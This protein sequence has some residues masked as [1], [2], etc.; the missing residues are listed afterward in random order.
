M[1]FNRPVITHVS[2]LEEF[3]SWRDY[4]RGLRE[5]VLLEA[6]RSVVAE[7]K[8]QAARECFLAFCDIMKAGD[9]KVAEFHEIIGSGFE[10]LANRRYKRL[11]VSCPPRSGK[12]MLATMFLAWL[13]GRDQ[14]TQHVIASYGAS[15]SFKFHRETVQ[16]L[17]SKEFKR[18]FPEWQGFSPDSK[19]DM[20]GGGYILATSIGGVLTGFT[21]GTTDMDSPGVGAMII[22]DPL[23]SSDSKQALD[24]L[25]S[26]WQE[27]ASTRRT[28]HFCQMVIATRFHEKDLHGV[29]MDGD[30][31]LDFEGNGPEWIADGKDFGWRW[32]N[33]SGL[34]EDPENDP[35][36]RQLGESHWPENS[37]FSVPMLESQKKIMGSFKF[38]ALYQGVPVASEGQ[39]VKSSWVEIIEEEDCPDLD[40]V[41]FGVDCAFSEREM[42]DESAIC[43]AGISTRTPD[44]V[45][46]RD[47]VKGKWGFPDLIESVKQQYAFYKAKV[48]CIEKA[49]SGHSLIQMLKREARIP[50]EE[51]RP[52]KSKTTRLQAVCPLLENSRVKLVRGLWTDPFV[53]EL[54][55]F[56]YVRHED[57]LDAMVWALTYYSLKLDTIDRGI[58]ESII[59]NRK[60]SGD[61]RRPA[62]SD[63]ASYGNLFEDKGSALGGRRMPGGGNLN[64]P[65]YQSANTP[66]QGLFR[67]GRSRSLRGGSGY[68]LWD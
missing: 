45:Y 26:W 65:D 51:M 58:Q 7:Y 41:W 34:C 5:L 64:D 52:L 10:D 56:P 8:Y 43:V 60:W 27:Q 25:E 4:K 21:A 54:T 35:L 42:A 59:Q 61:L 57:S 23:K 38:A 31:F 19:Y 30:G 9:L 33:I 20:V 6:P 16:M 17:K 53:K 36:G 62:F 68:N 48:L 12:S 18:I 2:Q 32:I 67:G 66:N 40:V 14:K 55:S 46:I 44:I 29:L 37:A 39:I 50:I 3:S 24:N 47:I 11:I 1:N 15:L 63:G 22:D 49:A 13:L 28:N